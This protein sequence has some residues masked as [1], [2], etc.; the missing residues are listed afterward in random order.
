MLKVLGRCS[1]E[2]EWGYQVYDIFFQASNLEAMFDGPS[3]L[4]LGCFEKKIPDLAL[5]K[6]CFD[7]L[8]Y[9]SMHSRI[10]FASFLVALENNTMSSTYTTCV[11]V[12]APMLAL[13][14]LMFLRLRGC[15]LLL[16]KQLFSVFK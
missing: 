10:V 8:Q 5:F 1:R 6:L 15:L 11:T 9:K 2:E 16:F 14:P 12:G 13:T 4:L 3:S 7:H